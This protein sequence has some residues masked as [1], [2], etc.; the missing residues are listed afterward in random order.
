MAVTRFGAYAT[1]INVDFR[2]VRA[3]PSQFSFAE[4]A[5]TLC[6]VG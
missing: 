2:L 6:Q 4:G 5:A 3:L 1:A